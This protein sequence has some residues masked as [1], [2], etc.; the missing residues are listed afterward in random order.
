[1]KKTRKIIALAMSLMLLMSMG[2]FAFG[3]SAEN[4]YTIVSPNED[5]IWTGDNAWGA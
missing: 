1:M 4:D 3:A 2:I 5:V